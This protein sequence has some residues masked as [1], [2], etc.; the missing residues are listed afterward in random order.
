[1]AHAVEF[2]PRARRDLTALPQRERRRVDRRIQ[3]LAENPRPRG[4]KKLHEGE[5]L[6]R[7]RAG[8]YRILYRVESRALVV[9][10][11]RIRHR[12]EAYR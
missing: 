9:L 10:V 11:V 5:G 7:V 3:A 4:V 2:T 1:M 8:D 12:R 6:Y